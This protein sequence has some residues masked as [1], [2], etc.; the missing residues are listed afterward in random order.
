MVYRRKW[1]I[2]R[3]LIMKTNLLQLKRKHP[4]W[5][6][7][8]YHDIWLNRY[9]RIIVEKASKQISREKDEAW[10]KQDRV[11]YDLLTMIDEMYQT[12][13]YDL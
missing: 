4:K 1:T 7:F 5:F 11:M 2:N 12:I 9:S 3:M 6:N 8:L 13:L 10:E